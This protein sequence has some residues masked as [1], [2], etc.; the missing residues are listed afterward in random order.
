MNYNQIQTPMTN[1]RSCFSFARAHP[2]IL[3]CLL[4]TTLTCTFC[5]RQTSH[6]TIEEQETIDRFNEALNSNLDIQFPDSVFNLALDVLAISEKAEDKTLVLY[7]LMKTG[8]R[9]IESM[10]PDSALYYS[11][12]MQTLAMEI[13]DQ[14]SLGRAYHIMSLAYIQKNKYNEAKSTIREAIRIGRHIEVGSEIEDHYANL[15]LLFE[16]TERYDSAIYYY[17][18]A[19]QLYET[20]NDL[21][22]LEI[23]FN[24]IGLVH[25]NTGNPKQAIQYFRKA[26]LIDRELNDSSSMSRIYN[27]IGLA[28]YE[29]GCYDTT[30]LYYD[31]AIQINKITGEKVRMMIVTY[32]LA[33]VLH[34]T[35]DYEQALKYNFDV[36]KQA[37]DLSVAVG[38]IKS[39]TSIGTIYLDL[40]NYSGAWQFLNEALQLAVDNKIFEDQENI[41]LQQTHA[42]IG[43]NDSDR[44]SKALLRYKKTIDSLNFKNQQEVVADLEAR[45]QLKEKD[46][47]LKYMDRVNRSRTNLNYALAA[48]IALAVFLF[49]FILLF[50]KTNL[51]KLGLQNERIG[52]DNK[53]KQLELEKAAIQTK[54]KEEEAEK[55]TLSIKLK[56]E[57]TGM[58]VHDLK[59]PLNNIINIQDD[60]PVHQNKK[61]RQ[62]G[63]QMLNM[64]LDIL[65]VYKYESTK[66]PIELSKNDLS[67]L[68]GKAVDEV[69]YAALEK[70]IVIKNLIPS[71]VVVNADTGLI[72]RVFVNLFTNAIKFTPTNGIVEINI[73]REKSNQEYIYLVVNDTGSG[74]PDEWQK[75]VF[76]K[77][78]QQQGTQNK[79]SGSIGLGLTFCKLAIEAHGGN[80]GV[81]KSDTSGTQVFFTLPLVSMS[82]DE[83]QPNVPTE[84]PIE[85]SDAEKSKLSVFLSKL[86]NL[87]IYEITALRKLLNEIEGEPDVNSEW[88]E[89]IKNAVNFGNEEQYK[90]LISK[91]KQ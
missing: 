29:M 47:K 25:T 46:T 82:K 77:F 5:T 48:I 21:E 66:L 1:Y 61:L 68:A 73:N 69:E 80:I 59:N 43:L 72:T 79:H 20:G 28:Y 41:L 30:R 27:N 56:E 45:Y 60:I 37:E 83:A 52:K 11:K 75:K 78:S 81:D 13:G 54:L 8:F 65:D 39:K 74:I 91:I 55:L 36:L 10:Y 38:I 19:A 53:L 50:Y 35:G 3:V 44:A 6:L 90:L 33:N 31:S 40:G 63:K 16:E 34:K 71:E 4:L 18:V 24:N 88:L 12:R 57:I 23:M 9:F 89:N 2:A 67:V 14:R 84:T 49:V 22:N 51:K 87:D 70:S 76:E 86:E 64:V 26:I 42:A 58:I 62:S 7:A 32:N 15:G 85:L 17:Q